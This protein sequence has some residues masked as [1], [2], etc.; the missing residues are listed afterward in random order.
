MTTTLKLKQGEVLKA[1]AFRNPGE[2][3]IEFARQY[4][5]PGQ[6]YHDM[7]DIMTDIIDGNF[8]EIHD[9]KVKRCQ[10]CGFYYRDKTKNNS[11]TTCSIECKAGKDAVLKTYNRRTKKREEGKAR[12][13]VEEL[14]Y[15]SH[16]EYPFWNGHGM[17][18][19]QLMFENDR[20]HNIYSYGDTLE[21]VVATAQRRAAMGGKKKVKENFGLY[22]G[23][24]SNAETQ[25]LPE[26]W[27]DT[28]TTG[29]KVKTIKK[30]KGEVAAELLERYGAEKLQRSREKALAHAK[31]KGLI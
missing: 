23:K 5:G 19:E 27:G 31:S 24:W 9:K 30:A 11:A 28:P 18:S 3:A 10:C 7:L 22:E 8:V 6:E 15:Y 25:R 21:A 13:S 1:T 14:Y 2:G 12:K 16:L 4:I 17:N 29:G 26:F 20:K